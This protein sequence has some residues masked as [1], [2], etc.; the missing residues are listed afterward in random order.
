VGEPLELRLHRRHHPRVSMAGVQN[1]NPAS[2]IDIA[3]AFD[4]P[5]FGV[6]GTGGVDG[7]GM[8]DPARHGRIPAFEKFC[9]G[10]HG[11][12]PGRGYVS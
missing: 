11:G 12:S 1:R 7:R 3:L 4:I 10:R 9:I 8:P 5:D 2:E 6:L